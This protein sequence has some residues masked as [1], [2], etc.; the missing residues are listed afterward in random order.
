VFQIYFLN[1][2]I[3]KRQQVVVAIKFQLSRGCLRFSAALLTVAHLGNLKILGSSLLEDRLVGEAGKSGADVLLLSHL[4]VLSE[5]L[6]T[7]PPVE[8]DHAQ[9][10]V[11]SNLMEVRV[12]DIVLDTVDGHSSVTVLKTGKLVG[13]TDSVAPVL[14]HLLLLVLDHNIEKE[15]APK[16]E[17]NHTPE[18][19]DTVLS[20]E[21]LHLPVHVAE[22][23]LEEAGNVLERSP[24]L[25]LV[26]RFLGVVD[27]FAEVAIGVLGQSSVT[28]SS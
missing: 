24:S 26:T 20:V 4:E 19:T 12:P 6:V 8:M 22:G 11:P 10:L 28:R 15:T 1:T 7:A 13:L 16:M 3:E 21:R 2:E 9:T 23:I 17:D 27:E 5:V 25:G 14:D 18:E